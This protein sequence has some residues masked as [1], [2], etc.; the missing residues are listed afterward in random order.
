M[1]GWVTVC[2]DNE[3]YIET[4]LYADIEEFWDNHGE[5]AE[6]ILIDIP[7]GLRED[8]NAKRPCDDVAR[9]KLSPN[10]HS[11]VFPVPV[12]DAVYADNY[13]AATAAQERKTDWSLGVLRSICQVGVGAR[14]VD[15]VH[16]QH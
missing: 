12:R 4:R 11:S 15:E 3:G 8:S 6:A 14:K 13:E 16:Q 7:I 1:D 5:S 9:E 10:R 2:Y